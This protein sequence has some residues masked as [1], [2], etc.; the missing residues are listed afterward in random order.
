M[1][2][3]TILLVLAMAACRDASRDS[4]AGT[5][6]PAT[7]LDSAIAGLAE[8]VRPVDSAFRAIPTRLRADSGTERVD[9]LLAEIQTALDRTTRDVATSFSDSLFRARIADADVRDSASAFLLSHGIWSYEAEGDRYF[10]LSLARLA[11]VASPF[12][13]DAAREALRIELREQ[14]S[15]TGGDAAVGIPWDSLGDRLAA[16]D[17]FLATF[18]HAAARAAISERRVWYLRAFLTGWEN[19]SVFEYR[20]KVLRPEIRRSFERFAKAHQTTASGQIVRAYLDFLA[21]TG[22]RR[23]PQV[24]EFLRTRAGIPH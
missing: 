8:R 14:V 23:T 9:S 10:V 1:A 24:N 19:T 16:T 15:P 18:P 21:T 22:Y 3:R 17:L 4:A 5:R 20:T 7:A 13:T 6:A 12:I 2:R 11:A